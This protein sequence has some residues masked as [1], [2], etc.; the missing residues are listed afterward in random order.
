MSVIDYRL[1][2]DDGSRGQHAEVAVMSRYWTSQRYGL[3][4]AHELN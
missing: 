1:A 3:F 2:D 4:T